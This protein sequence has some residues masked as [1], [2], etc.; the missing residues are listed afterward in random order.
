MGGKIQRGRIIF[1]VDARSGRPSTVKFAEIKENIDQRIRD[2]QRIINHK[3]FA[4]EFIMRNTKRRYKM[5]EDITGNIL[6]AS[7]VAVTSVDFPTL[8]RNTW[9]ISDILRVGY[10][11]CNKW[12]S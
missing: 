7:Y 8:R 9:F 12:D 5:A 6:R 11:Q 2:N 10:L 4:S 1:V 3:I